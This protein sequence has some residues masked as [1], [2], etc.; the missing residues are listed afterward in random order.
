MERSEMIVENHQISYRNVASKYYNFVPEEIDLAF[1]DF[2]QILLNNG[3]HIQDTMFFSIIS[4]PTAPVMTAEI[5]RSI[6]ESYVSD[7]KAAEDVNFRSY[8]SVNRML[9]TRITNEFDA[10]S[11]EKY[12]ELVEHLQKNNFNQSSPIF[13]EYKRSHSGTV[14]AEMSVGVR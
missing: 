3:F 9:M 5:F 2:D 1:A 12:W 8:F 7:M 11:Q 13:V 4:D 10:Q 14:Y 6:E